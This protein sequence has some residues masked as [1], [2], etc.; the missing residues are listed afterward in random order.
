MK[1]YASEVQ[2][3][4]F[5]SRDLRRAISDI[6]RYPLRKSAIDTL[7]R[8]LRS[9]I[10]NMTLSQLV[11]D[12]RDEDRLCLIQ[13]ESEATYEPKI[14]CSLGLKSPTE[15]ADNDVEQTAGSALSE[16]L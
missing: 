11:I 6:Y 14:I 4:L 5:D 9:G 13:E 16:K 8:Q 7:N 2:G 12:L 1:D 15:E 10:S 3:T